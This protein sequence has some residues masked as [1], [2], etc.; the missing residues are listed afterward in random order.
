MKQVKAV[1]GPVTV[2][3]MKHLKCHIKCRLTRR[4]DDICDNSISYNLSSA[5]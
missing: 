1:E 3:M 5:G 2:N 4:F